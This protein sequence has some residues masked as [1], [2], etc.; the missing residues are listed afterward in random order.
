MPQLLL[1]GQRAAVQW[2]AGV[3]AATFLL[4]GICGLVPGLTTDYALLKM[5]GPRSG[6]E[7]FGLFDVS[8]LHNVVH[9]LFGA[10]GLTLGNTSRGARRFLAVGA[11][12][13]LALG[14][15]GFFVPQGSSANVLPLDTAGSWLHVGLAVIMVILALCWRVPEKS[16]PPGELSRQQD[17]VPACR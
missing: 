4:L 17:A 5:A 9:L 11:V 14:L 6:A 2:A 15:Y 3:V 12:V 13:A 8:V 16:T 1:A 7:L 10:A